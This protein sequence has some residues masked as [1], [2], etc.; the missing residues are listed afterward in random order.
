LSSQ[1]TPDQKPH[2]NVPN[3]EVFSVSFRRAT[4]WRLG[5]GGGFILSFM[6]LDRTTV[7]FQMWQGISTWYPPVGL[8]LALL[9]GIDLSYA[10]LVLVAGAISSV[11]N[12][13]LSPFSLSFWLTNATVGIGYSAA[14]YVLRRVLRVDIAFRTLRDVN[15]FVAVAL[16]SSFCVG[17]AGS[18]AFVWG[19]SLQWDD[20]YPAV[21]NWWV[22]DAVAI[23]CLTPFLLVH[24]APWLCR[25][26]AA[27]DAVAG[28]SRLASAAELGHN[29]LAARNFET[30]GQA[31]GILLS[32]WIVFEWN[33]VKG[34]GLFYLFFLPILWIA[35]RR[36]LRGVTVAVALLSC[37]AMLMLRL[38]G[39]DPRQLTQFQILMLIV[40]LTGLSVGTVIS[41]RGRAEGEA[42][43]GAARLEAL[44]GSIDELVFEFDGEGVYK[45]VWATNNA[46]LVRLKEEL[47]G[48]RASEFISED[49]V[50]PL[51]EIF[52]RVLN[53]KQSESLEYSVPI[54]T[55]N[56]WFLARITAIPAYRGQPKTVC[57][58]ARDITE[59]K[60]AEEELRNAKE[61]AEAAS[62]AKSQ[63]L[64]NMSHE[65]RTPMNGII[66]MTE[67]A[68]DTDLNADQR[69]YLEMVKISADSLLT[70]LNDIL[71]FSKIE[72]G[73]MDLEPIEFGFEP[74][75][76][77]TLK[78]VRFR[79]RQK[80]LEF[81]WHVGSRVPPIVIG[82]PA[83][84]RQVLINLTGNAI[85]F[86]Q[87]GG[88]TVEVDTEESD[89]AEPN[90][91][92][93]E[94]HFQV[95][96]TGIG[97][98]T[99]K[100]AVIFDAFT[101]ADSSTT[102][103][104]GGTG[105]GLAISTSLVKLMGGRIWVESAPGNGSTFHFTAGFE[106]PVVENVGAKQPRQ[107]ESVR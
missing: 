32:L 97:I 4:L 27:G 89:A 103:K 39:A 80:G 25:R 15:W 30:A 104:F 58:T 79:A 1:T 106:L 93:V 101:Q 26:I 36:G 74:N 19:K 6:L 64:A 10:P 52:R 7:Y 91:Q 47:I 50:L 42:R 98:P 12:Y 48:R 69:E 11:V 33:P 67:L 66:G 81:S 17:A 22:G 90:A 14:A 84:L 3:E 86:T 87:R 45:N 57:M 82:D 18:A 5:I 43:E 23:V 24:V 92:H 75:L 40:S 8:A 83:R 59:R 37:G 29:S 49:V 41:E 35:V 78:L 63:F 68:L 2:G 72:A 21:L 44:V 46:L 13:H 99:E 62:L 95:R 105:L 96:D 38:N 100:Q 70:L 54:G 56:R 85:K 76:R 61:S 16:A 71:D 65:I 53:T 60:R 77:E 73:K 31:G 28:S 51:V 88:I 34:Y 94:L 107:S 55:E 9:I 102:R 20:Y